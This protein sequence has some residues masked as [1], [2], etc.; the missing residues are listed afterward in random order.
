MGG[1]EKALHRTTTTTTTNYMDDHNGPPE[2]FKNPRANNIVRYKKDV[3]HL[4]SDPIYQSSTSLICLTETHVTCIER[5]IELLDSSW[6]EIH[7][8]SEHGLCI[9]Y[10]HLKI[11][12]EKTIQIRPSIEGLAC[13]FR[14]DTEPFILFLLYRSPSGNL[15][16]F[17]QEFTYQLIDL[18]TLSMRIV[19]VGDFNANQN[20]TQ[21]I[22]FMQSVLT[23]F[24]FRLRVTFAT[25]IN[26]RIL[27]LIMDSD[28]ENDTQAD[29]LPSPYSNHYL[30]FYEI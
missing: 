30:L 19:I 5:D 27:D 10:N 20:H 11:K 15:R 14:N 7:K 25:H 9:A 28:L 6:K 21:K 22:N 24:S 16:E 1:P 3:F 13:I 29:Y 2:F 4:F 17:I 18:Q 12:F 23:Q 26:G 8:I